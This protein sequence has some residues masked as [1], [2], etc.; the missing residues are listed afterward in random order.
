[1]ITHAIPY[2]VEV[3][4]VKITATRYRQIDETRPSHSNKAVKQRNAAKRRR[5][6]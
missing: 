4:G 3:A 1:M 5:R 6:Q 2:S